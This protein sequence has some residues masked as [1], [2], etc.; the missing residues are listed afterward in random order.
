[1]IGFESGESCSL[2]FKVLFIIRHPHGLTTEYHINKSANRSSLVQLQLE[3]K[4]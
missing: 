2:A 4:L 1:M 3:R